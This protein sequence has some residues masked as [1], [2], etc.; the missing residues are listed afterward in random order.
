MPPPRNVSS[1]CPFRKNAEKTLSSGESCERAGVPRLALR[2]THGF[3]NIMS[4]APRVQRVIRSW[5]Y[6]R[7]GIVPQTTGSSNLFFVKSGKDV[8]VRLCGAWTYVE[9][10]LETIQRPEFRRGPTWGR[11]EKHA[12]VMTPRP[13]FR[14]SLSRALWRLSSPTSLTDEQ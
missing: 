11:N 7:A 3:V 13:F 12:L 4:D 2:T 14:S 1:T 10:W 5:R 6:H 9:I 8:Q